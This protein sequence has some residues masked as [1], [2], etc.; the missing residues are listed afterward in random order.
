VVLQNT[1]VNYALGDTIVARFELGNSSA[2]RKR[3]SVLI[4]AS[5][6]SDLAVCTFWLPPGVPLRAYA[7]RTHTTKDWTTGS[8]ISFYAASEGS[9]GGFYQVDNVVMGPGSGLS[10]QRTDCVDPGEPGTSLIA[11]TPELLTNGDF[12][13]GLA[14][15][16]AYGT[17]TAQVT[18]GVAQFIRPSNDAPS[19]ALLQPS[20]DAVP[21]GQTLVATFQL[22]NSSASRKRVTV[23]LH[24]FTW[25]DLAACTFW[26]P[27]GQPLMPYVMRTY[28]TQAWS[29][30]TISFY[31]ATTDTDQ[32]FELDR[33]SLTVSPSTPTFGTDCVEPFGDEAF[34]E[35]A[36]QGPGLQVVALEPGVFRPRGVPRLSWGLG[37]L[38]P[39]RQLPGLRR[40]GPV[41]VVARSVPV[42]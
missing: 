5:D 22:G 11:D 15:W 34:T 10:A 24:E 12:T 25:G 35:T 23:I 17:I 36:G 8:T 4:H 38:S 9:D 28:S 21:A 40:S 31:P 6:W 30:A 32:W 20:G 26:M 7:M 2:A 29:N 1:A 14:S 37:R 3:I 33:V 39:V 13:N 41:A 16:T 27:A 18:G 19:G 42:V